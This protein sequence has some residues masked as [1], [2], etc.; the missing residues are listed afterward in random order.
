MALLLGARTLDLHGITTV[1]GNASLEQTTRNARQT[2]EFAELTDIPIAEGM[3]RPL[4]RDVRHAPEVHGETG[5]DGP[6]LPPPT[7]PLR[8]AGRDRLHR[9]A[10]RAPRRP[11]PRADWAPDQRRRRAVPGSV[12]AAAGQADQSDGRLA[13]LWQCHAGGRVQYLV[14]SRGRARRLHQR[15]PDQDDRSQRHAAGRRPPRSGGR[16]SAASATAPAA[17]SPTCSIS[18]AGSC[19]SSSGWLAGRCTIRWRWP[20][21]STPRS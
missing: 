9:L 7:V 17:S 14:R 11:G 19:R 2:V 10:S 20:P 15:H 5:L 16:R 8:R 3:A 21:W 4:V 1:F 13:D 6:T 12:A 18:T